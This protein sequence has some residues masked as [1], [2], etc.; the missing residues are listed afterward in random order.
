M[1]WPRND[2][3]NENYTNNTKLCLPVQL[4]SENEKFNNAHHK[5]LLPL[6]NPNRVRL[7][8]QWIMIS[9][10]TATVKQLIKFLASGMNIVRLSYS[11]GPVSFL[12][13]LLKNIRQAR[14][15]YSQQIGRYVP[16]AI[17]TDDVGSVIQVGHFLKEKEYFPKGHQVICTEDNAFFHKSNRDYLYIGLKN[18]H[19]VLSPGNKINIDFDEVVLAVDGVVGTN[20]VC[21]VELAGYLTSRVKVIIFGTHVSSSKFSA[22]DF[23]ALSFAVKNNLDIFCPSSIENAED[24]LYIRKKIKTLGGNIAIVPKIDNWEGK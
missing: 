22:E 24:V 11:L 16:L 9:K 8:A 15:E 4:P 17:S 18:M 2:Y 14:E 6:L 13:E 1:V 23:K 3:K 20:I 5:E 19:V 10:E 12:L 7:T 21:T